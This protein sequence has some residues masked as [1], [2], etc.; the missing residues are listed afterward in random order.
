MNYILNENISQAF[1]D[2]FYNYMYSYVMVVSELRY[3]CVCVCIH[4][5]QGNVLIYKLDVI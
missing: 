4:Y 1:G 5:L 3:M 2:F